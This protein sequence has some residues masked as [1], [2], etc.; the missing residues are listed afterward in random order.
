MTDSGFT[1]QAKGLGVASLFAAGTSTVN[2][3]ATENRN[4]EALPSPE[5][6][7]L[8]AENTALQAEINNISF[9]QQLQ[10]LLAKGLAPQ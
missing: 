3:I 2:A 4:A 8:A 1:S 7:R 6:A 10:G 9:R 5:T